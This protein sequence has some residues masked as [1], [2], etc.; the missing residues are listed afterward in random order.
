MRAEAEVILD[1]LAGMAEVHEGKPLGEAYAELYQAVGALLLG[2]ESTR[3][4][5]KSL[6][7]FLEG[8]KSERARAAREALEKLRAVSYTDGKVIEE[9]LRKA[10]AAEL[11]HTRLSLYYEEVA[12]MWEVQG[13]LEDEEGERRRF[14]HEWE[15]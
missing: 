13:Y 11:D 5:L 4:H 14:A 1:I 7:A 15:E 10:V 2:E 12:F 3:E 9:A 6:G 8:G